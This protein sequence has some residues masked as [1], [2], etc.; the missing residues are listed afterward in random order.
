M[1]LEDVRAL[2]DQAAWCMEQYRVQHATSLLSLDGRKLTCAFVAPDTEAMRSVLRQVGIAYVRLWPAVIHAALDHP[3]SAGLATPSASLVV[4]ERRF[5]EPVE[6][7][8]Q[9]EIEDRGATCLT[10]H[11]VR[12]LR[13]YVSLDRRHMI[14]TYAAPDTESVRIAQREAGMPFDHAWTALVYE[15]H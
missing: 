11:R 9:Q 7:P 3:P 8:A 5:V 12:F 14:S 6:A 15:T 4:V 10:A 13:A 1:S 2:G